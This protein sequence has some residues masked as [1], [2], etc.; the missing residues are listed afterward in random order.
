MVVV[1]GVVIVVI[2]IVVVAVVAVEIAAAS[3]IAVHAVHAV[4]AGTAVASD[5]GVIETVRAHD[6]VWWWMDHGSDILSTVERLRL[7]SC[8][9]V[10]MRWAG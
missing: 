3:V 7:R 9:I 1:V 2:V 10:G 5:T 6:S 4:D 8:H